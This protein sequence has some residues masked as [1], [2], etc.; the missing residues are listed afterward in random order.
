MTDLN[1]NMVRDYSWMEEITPIGLGDFFTED[2]ICFKPGRYCEIVFTENEVT[3]N[4]SLDE[5]KDAFPQYFKWNYDDW[6]FS[7]LLKEDG[8]TDPDP[9][10]LD[11]EEFPYL[12]HHVS[13]DNIN[14][15]IRNLEKVT[16]NN[17]SQRVST[18]FAEDSHQL[19]PKIITDRD[20]ILAYH[21]LIQDSLDEGAYVNERY[22]LNE[23]WGV[24]DFKK[25][26]FG[27]IV[28]INKKGDDLKFVIKTNKV[29]EYKTFTGFLKDFCEEV[30]FAEDWTDVYHEPWGTYSD[31]YDTYVE[32]F[33]NFMAKYLSENGDTIKKVNEICNKFIE[34]YTF[35]SKVTDDG[36]IFYKN[37]NRGLVE[38]IVIRIVDMVNEMVQ[39][40]LYDHTQSYWYSDKNKKPIRSITIN[41]DEFDELFKNI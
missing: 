33:N 7:T 11:Y 8:Y 26:S 5:I 31:E 29:L 19:V 9:S 36:V 37:V 3:F 22:K 17:L 41:V 40:D 6:F 15:M 21:R 12:M 13:D 25:N 24:F 4:I 23:M 28:S 14:L 30:L 27:G 20:V 16:P 35:T 1:K 18:Y 32:S 2:S 38:S 39:V 10:E 34:P